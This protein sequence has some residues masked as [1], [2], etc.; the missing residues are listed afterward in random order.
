VKDKA[1]VAPSTP[2]R[3]STK[4]RNSRHSGVVEFVAVGASEN[5]TKLQSSGR[6]LQQV[7]SKA[8][9]INKCQQV[10]IGSEKRFGTRGSEVQILSPRP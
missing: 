4:P 8:L 7:Q 3:N 6:R 5:L 9:T 10:S 1:R 2:E